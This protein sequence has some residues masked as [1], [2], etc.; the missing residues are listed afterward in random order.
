MT[1]IIVSDPFVSDYDIAFDP[2]KEDAENCYFAIYG[3]NRMKEFYYG[4][5]EK[6]VKAVDS[7]GAYSFETVLDDIGYT[8]KADRVKLYKLFNRHYCARC[9]SAY[10]E[11]DKITDILSY[12]TGDKWENTTIRGSS[13]SEWQTVIYNTRYVG[14]ENSSDYLTELA[15]AYFGEVY[16]LGII[17]DDTQMPDIE[18]VDY[19]DFIPC[20]LADHASIC[21]RLGFAPDETK[22][23]KSEEHQTTTYTYSEV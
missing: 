3:N 9:G 17:E 6:V 18:N 12:I 2:F 7:W 20:H 1:K 10:F 4:I 8:P 16:S 22:I 21:S 11:E 14:N 13:Q 5:I 23:Y 15:C 19:W